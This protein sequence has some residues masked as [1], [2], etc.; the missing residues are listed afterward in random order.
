VTPWTKA[1]KG[2]HISAAAFKTAMNDASGWRPERELQTGEVP[3]GDR[4]WI[5][6]YS[7]QGQLEGVEVLQNFYLIAGPDGEQVV[8]TFTLAPKQ[9]DK[10]GARDLSLAGSVEVPAAK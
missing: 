9:A 8:L 6:R 7:V 10:L 3:S 5:Y 2:E 1:K 4:R